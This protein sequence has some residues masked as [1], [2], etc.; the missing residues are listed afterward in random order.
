[1]LADKGL[2]LDAI[3]ELSVDEEALASRIAKRVEE[4]IAAGGKVR[5]D[6]NPEA[7]RKRLAVFREQTAPLSGYYR[8]DGRLQVVDGMLSI[9]EVTDAIDSILGTRV[10]ERI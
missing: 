3:I 10:S 7:F 4:T 5:P 6:D 1:M 2:P 8:R 9:A